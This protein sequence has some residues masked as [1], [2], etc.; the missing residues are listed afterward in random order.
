[1][2]A[3]RP[4]AEDHTVWRHWLTELAN[5]DSPFGLSNQVLASVV[6]ITT[7]PRIWKNASKPSSAIAFANALL[8]H[9]NCRTINPGPR[10]WEIY[11]RLCAEPGVTG[12]LTQDAWLAAL[13][14]EHG[15]EWVTIDGD[16]DRFPGL[17]WR[18]LL[19]P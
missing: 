12:N 19:R 9:P 3:F 8:D 10:H 5:G 6:R 2:K 16:F 1:M 13:A 4:D 11:C 7:H 18:R 14:I 17:R 15:C